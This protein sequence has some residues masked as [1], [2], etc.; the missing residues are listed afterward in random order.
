MTSR[1]AKLVFTF[2]AAIC[3]GLRVNLKLSVIDGLSGFYEGGGSMPLIFNL[4]LLVGV[5]LLLLLSLKRRPEV[6]RVLEYRPCVRLL[7]LLLGAATLVYAGTEL[8]K[9]IDEQLSLPG[10][11]MSLAIGLTFTGLVF[12]LLPALAAFTLFRVGL[13]ARGDSSGF[14]ISPYLALTPVLWQVA[15]LLTLFMKYTAVRH[16][17]DQLL[18]VLMLICFVPFLLSNARV[19]SD[20]SHDRGVG[21]LA[22]FGLPF[23]LLAFSVSAGV[24]AS[25]VVGNPLYIALS[26]PGAIF[27]LIAG[28]YATVVCF[29]VKE[30]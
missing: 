2:F 22:T 6:T 12:A 30:V 4:L 20:V 21:R 5:A 25:Y 17:S 23:A 11:T 7:S 28:V 13:G 10:D 9:R 3:A 8:L 24:I 14:R 19:L 15:L 29:S 1:T 18:T 16:V 26:L 27:F